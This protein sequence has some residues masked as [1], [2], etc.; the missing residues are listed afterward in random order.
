MFFIA[1]DELYMIG[2]NTPLQIILSIL[3][4]SRS[5]G[6]VFFY[7][8]S[9]GATKK[10]PSH[11]EFLPSSITMSDEG[12]H[13]DPSGSS[14]VPKS[15]YSSTRVHKGPVHVARL[16]SAGRYLLTGGAD[17]QIHLFNATSR[18]QDQSMTPIK[19]YSSHS[20]TI[21]GLSISQDNAAFVSGG[22]DRNVIQWD[23]A[24]GSAVRRFSAHTGATQVV[25]YCG[26]DTSA[27]N[28]PSE[29]LLTA[30]FDTVLRFYDLRARGAWKPIM[31]SKEAKDT[32][33]CAAVR[34][35][36][37]YTGCV[38]GVLRTYDL[39]AGQLCEDTFDREY[40]MHI[41][42]RCSTMRQD[43]LCRSLRQEPQHRCL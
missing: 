43:R 14:S 9:S 25:E 22:E 32:I 35:H 17:R 27:T 37:I 20:G 38:D 2:N 26:G 29:V 8:G 40:V 31:E 39:R 15:V 5:V 12:R 23:V 41:P 11:L 19:T 28:S 16:N 1:H 7:A 24:S 10:R 36:S 34:G 18:N 42:I 21:L 30:G 33:L 3:S 13:Q 6:Y 4:F